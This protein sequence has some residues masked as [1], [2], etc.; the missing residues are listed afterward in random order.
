MRAPFWRRQ[1]KG[2]RRRRGD[3]DLSP[4]GR[5]RKFEFQEESPSVVR[6]TFSQVFSAK[7]WL[8]QTVNG[9]DLDIEFESYGL[10]NFEFSIKKE[11]IYDS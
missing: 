10:A 9:C 2:R 7:C 6:P 1:D 4:S 11:P 8:F 3:D 5:E